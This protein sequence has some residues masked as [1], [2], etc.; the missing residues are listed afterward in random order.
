MKKIFLILPAL[1]AVAFAGCATKAQ[2][3]GANED[4]VSDFRQGDGGGVR[5][6]A[7]V[8]RRDGKTVTALRGE[9]T[10]GDFSRINRKDPA[11]V[12]AAFFDSYLRQTGG[13]KNL[14]ADFGI[15]GMEKESLIENMS[16]AH[17]KLYGAADS[18][19][20]TIHPEKIERNI[21]IC[22]FT[23]KIGYSYRGE[24]GEGEDQVSMVQYKNEE[25]FVME[26]PR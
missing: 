25:W 9:K 22:Y 24:E 26:L 21:D 20:I 16:E 3:A 13:W 8:V 1:I 10:A 2:G 18:I 4:A 6:E 11:Q 19:S 5:S 14:V 23:I 17:E 7:Y 15:F 12:L